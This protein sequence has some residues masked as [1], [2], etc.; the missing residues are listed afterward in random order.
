MGSTALAGINGHPNDKRSKIEW[1]PQDDK[2]NNST[3]YIICTKINP[4]QP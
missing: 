2:I 1:T 3:N 4:S